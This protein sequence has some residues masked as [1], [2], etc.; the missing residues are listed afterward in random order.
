M[1]V[2]MYGGCN[3]SLSCC[4]MLAAPT[5]QRENAHMNSVMETHANA[6]TPLSHARRSNST[7]QECANARKNSVME[8]HANTHTPLSQ[9][10]R[11]SNSTTREC[12]NA[13]KWTRQ[14]ENATVRRDRNSHLINVLDV[15]PLSLTHST[16]TPTESNVQCEVGGGQ[17]TRDRNMHAHT[18]AM[19]EE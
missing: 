2:Y 12:E 7:T 13:T 15:K 5:R 19:S 4:R 3:R 11:R 9:A 14:R 6:Y 10:R 18:N 16:V 8:T 17:N 1:T